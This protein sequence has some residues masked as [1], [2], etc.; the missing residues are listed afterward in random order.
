[1]SSRSRHLYSMNRRLQK[2]HRERVWNAL[3][4]CSDASG[5]RQLQAAVTDWL[6]SWTSELTFNDKAQSY[7]EGELGA[8]WN[9]VELAVNVTGLREARDVFMNRGVELLDVRFLRSVAVALNNA[10]VLLYD[11]PKRPPLLTS[12][13]AS[14]ETVSATSSQQ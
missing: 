14:G 10:T 8:L 1:M 2:Q 12:P 5:H 11:L 6:F 13:A 3:R 4:T 9:D 7:L